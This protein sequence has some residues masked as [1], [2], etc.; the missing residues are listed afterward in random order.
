M[1][2]ELE[3][4][5]LCGNRLDDGEIHCEWCQDDP[6]DPGDMD[7]DLESGLASAGWGT[8]EA[9]E[10]DTPLYEDYYGGE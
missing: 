9:Y 8:D 6:G 4:L 10:H 7:G 5:C 3:L 1:D 2:D